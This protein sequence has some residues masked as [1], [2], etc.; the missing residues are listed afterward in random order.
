MVVDGWC[1]CW[2]RYDGGLQWCLGDYGLEG[3]WTWFC[4]GLELSSRC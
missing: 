4:G 1:E 2:L 3:E